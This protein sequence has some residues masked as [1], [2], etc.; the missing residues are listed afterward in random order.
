[1]KNYELLTTEDGVVSMLED[2]REVSLKEAVG[3]V[4]FSVYRKTVEHSNEEDAH[5]KKRLEEKIY[6]Q[7]KVLDS[8]SN[9]LNAIK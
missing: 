2:G 4:A 7:S 9:A 8:L 6:F 5:K 3:V 1:M